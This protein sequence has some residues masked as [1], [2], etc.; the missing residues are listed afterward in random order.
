M[1]IIEIQL[2]WY[3]YVY[4]SCEY[5]ID[6]RKV[7]NFYIVILTADRMYENFVAL[8]DNDGDNYRNFEVK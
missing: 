1:I 8:P 7:A 2:K 5:K 3:S 4:Y 6:M